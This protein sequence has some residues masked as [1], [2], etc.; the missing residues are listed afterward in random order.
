MSSPGLWARLAYVAPFVY[1]GIQI[2]SKRLLR[3]AP[4]GAFSTN[5]LWDRAIEQG[6]CFGARQ[7]GGPG[8]AVA[9]ICGSRA[10]ILEEGAPVPV[11]LQVA[12]PA[13]RIAAGDFAEA[14]EVD[15]PLPWLDRAAGS[16]W[17]DSARLQQ[18]MWNL[19]R[20]AVRYARP[21]P[22]SVRIVLDGYA[23]PDSLNPG[24]EVRNYAKF[25]YTWDQREMDAISGRA[26]RYIHFKMKGTRR[27]STG[28]SP[29][30]IFSIITV[31]APIAVGKGSAYDLYLT[32][33]IKNAEIVRAYLDLL[34]EAV[35]DL[36]GANKAL[37][38]EVEGRL[39][40]AV[41][42]EDPRNRGRARS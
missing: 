41:P 5:I 32:R 6:R 13:F 26:M 11:R 35:T 24:T 21:E 17:G 25:T 39:G 12:R 8:G 40:R 18:V 33:T 20:N 2:V 16:V 4:Q 23:G 34:G 38:A 31:G 29:R 42:G 10:K 27:A 1:T 19:L 9:V 37:M 3:D 14:L 30:G 15:G 7:V 22:K 36:T 28:S